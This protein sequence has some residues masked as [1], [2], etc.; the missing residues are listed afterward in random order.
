MGTPGNAKPE[1]NRRDVDDAKV[2]PLR[3]TASDK[4][5]EV[6]SNMSDIDERT[7]S[8]NSAKSLRPSVS[9][10]EKATKSPESLTLESDGDEESTSKNNLDGEGVEQNGFA[11]LLSPPKPECWSKMMACLPCCGRKKNN[12]QDQNCQASGGGHT[13]LSYFWGMVDHV[14]T[15]FRKLRS[16]F[17]LCLKPV[18]W[19]CE[20]VSGFC[21]ICRWCFFKSRAPERINDVNNKAKAVMYNVVSSAAPRVV[22]CGDYLANLC[23]TYITYIIGG[24]GLY[25]AAKQLPQWL[26]YLLND[27]WRPEGWTE[28]TGYYHKSCDYNGNCSGGYTRYDD[29]YMQRGPYSH[30]H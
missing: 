28:P 14:G 4:R 5:S 16:C 24:A 6:R 26:K 9:S 12:Q 21:S 13:M 22:S 27:M 25:W 3:A 10:S 17:W 2:N 19:I 11:T 30:L 1:M 7:D 15:L 23:K 18:K 8:A 20:L 29:P